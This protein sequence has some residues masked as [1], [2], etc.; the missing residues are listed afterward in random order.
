MLNYKRRLEDQRRMRHGS[1]PRHLID[2][3]D[4]KI[5]ATE[6]SENIDLAR[7]SLGSIRGCNGENAE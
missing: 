6:N 7:E 2:F 1:L 3:S 4:Y 5:Q